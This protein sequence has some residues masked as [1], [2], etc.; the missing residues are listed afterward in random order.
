MNYSNTAFCRNKSKLR[1]FNLW[2]SSFYALYICEYI[3]NL[4]RRKISEF[5]ERK[6]KLRFLYIRWWEFI[7][8]SG[9]PEA[10]FTTEHHLPLSFSREAQ[11]NR[12]VIVRQILR[13]Q[14]GSCREHRHC[15]W[16]Q[17]ETFDMGRRYRNRQTHRQS[18]STYKIY[19]F[20]NAI[21][22]QQI[23]KKY[24]TFANKWFICKKNVKK[25]RFKF[26]FSKV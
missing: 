21:W 2:R 12:L 14:R 23:K 7:G 17:C 19:Y 1:I 18:K 4:R 16:L 3:G 8:D 9:K 10:F 15:R 6:R 20:N 24:F 11:R 13:R 22:V 26:F 25:T 5:R